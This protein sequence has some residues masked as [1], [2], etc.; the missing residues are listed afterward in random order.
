M[1]KKKILWGLFWYPRLG[2]ETSLFPHV[3]NGK[4]TTGEHQNRPVFHHNSAPARTSAVV[5]YK[6]QDLSYQVLQHYSYSPDLEFSNY[7]LFPNGKIAARKEI[8]I[9]RRPEC[10][11]NCL[12]GLLWYPRLGWE[13][14]WVPH[15]N[16]GT[17]PNRGYQNRHLN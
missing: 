3:N 7:Y 16:N 17:Q 12:R 9:E 14:G 5:S 15:V 6:L 1:R 13:L 4:S 2:W 10:R 11:T 8:F